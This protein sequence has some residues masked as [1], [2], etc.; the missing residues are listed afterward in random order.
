M[1]AKVQAHLCEHIGWW[2]ESGL[3][4][5]TGSA[6]LCMQWTEAAPWAGRAVV[7]AHLQSWQNQRCSGGSSGWGRRW[8]CRQ[9]TW[10]LRRQ[11]RPSQHTISP[12]SLH[13]APACDRACQPPPAARA[14]QGLL[15]FPDALAVL[16]MVAHDFR[17]SD[18][19]AN[20][21]QLGM[22]SK[23]GRKSSAGYAWQQVVPEMP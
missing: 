9:S 6:W 17:L 19:F 11:T 23:H 1:L 3:P 2:P 13:T 8:G 22:A 21:E 16:P 18:S 15:D 20:L 12:P 10:K 4:S 7:P 5:D 14:V